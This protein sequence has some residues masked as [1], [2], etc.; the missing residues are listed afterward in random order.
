MND[1]R[2]E[3]LDVI[4]SVRRR[5]RQ[6]LALRG[7][8]AV[9]AGTLVALFLSASSLE[10]LRF[11]P[12]AIVAFRVIA[13]VVFAALVWYFLA[14]PVRRRVS[15]SQV[16]MYLEE[17]DP[18]LEAA[19]LSAVEASSG[20][21]F[22]AS[23]SPHL[24]DR[25]VERAIEQCR[26]AE[27]GHAVD[28][29]ALRRHAMTL[30]GV[31]AAA[32]LLIVV[33]PAYLRSGLSALL[34][35]YRSAAAASPYNIEVQPGDA[36][37]PRGSDQSVRARLLGFE[38]GEATLNVRSSAGASFERIPLVAG[39]DPAV[40]E[41]MLFHVETTT[42][43]FVESNGVHSPTFSL[44]VLDLPTVDRLE[45]EYHF[46]AYTGLPPQRVEFGGDVA[47]LRGTEVRMR[48]VP[49]MK[50]PGGKVLV[51]ESGSGPLTPAPD[52]SLSGGFT[53]DQQGFYRIELTG[54][55]GERVEASP[56]YTIDVLEDQPPIVA[57]T[58]P[59]RDSSASPVE[60]VFLE[61]RADDDFGIRQLQL[62]YTVNGSQEQTVT[63]F[64]GGRTLQ[65]V[66]AG[67]TLFLEELGLEPGDFVS[68]YARAIDNSAAGGSR[69]TTSDIYF[70]QIR[71]FRRDFRAAQSAAG[72]GAGSGSEVGQLSQQQREIVAATFNV[73]RDR[74]K[75]PAD[76]F[77]E[78]VV[79]LTLAQ[80]K[81]RE[82]VDELVGKLQAR[83]GVV[84]SEF[85]KIAELLPKASAEMRSAEGQLKAQQAKDA[86]VP[87]QG[88]LKY[89]QEAEQLYE[90]QVAASQGGGGGSG[91]SALADD[92]ADLFE[93]E[94][95]KLANQ[96]EMEKRAEQQ[97]GDR[98]VDELAA[99]LKELARRQMQ[100]AERQ[101]R[102]AAAGQNQSGGGSGAS[103]RQLAEELEE[104]ARRL[105][106]LTREQQRPEFAEA[107]RRMQE[108]AQ[109]M[110]QAAASG[111]QDG[112]ALANAALDKLREAQRLLERNQSGR[113]ERDIRNAQRQ[114]EE[115]AE[116]QRDITSQVNSLD[117]DGGDR[118]ARAQGLGQRK[119]AMDA[120]VA[121]LQKQLERLANDTR[122]DQR[123]ASRRLDEAANSIRDKRV[124]EKIRYSRNA[125]QG[126]PSDYARAMEED[127][128][129]NLNALEQ[130][131]GDAA[132]ALGEAQKQDALA[133]AVDKTGDLVRSLRS[134]DERMRQDRSESG[135]A[136][137]GQP[138]R[139]GQQGQQGQEGQQGQ[140]QEG[141]GQEGQNGQ[142]EG[143][144]AQGGR[145]G[146]PNGPYNGSP[147]LGGSGDARSWGYGPWNHDDIRQFRREFREWAADAERLRR[148]LA[149][150][151][152]NPRELD[153]IL[154]GLRGLDDERLYADPRGLEKLQAAALERLQKFEFELRKQVDPDRGTLALSASD[155]VPAGFREAIEEYY[156]QLAKKSR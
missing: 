112:G 64:G 70:V 24:V 28:R 113:T 17:R 75:M 91:Q 147:Q 32:A 5:W 52:G 145:F 50:T 152:V 1:R 83:L 115:L 74:A 106:Q 20:S 8:V 110:R 137:G 140:G 126:P 104:A 4:G 129:A 105:Q 117:Q 60:E 151:G 69:T 38:A 148:E 130:K 25:L 123:E 3:L 9:V 81:L 46:P 132:A 61:A 21:E 42:E 19:I 146:N 136:S 27:D 150:A 120:K 58:K 141:R 71:P 47:A 45:L 35:V 55:N 68:Y 62:V 118:Q 10:A 44:S 89:L 124:R 23:H 63:L 155:E 84:D 7:V 66:T 111:A 87:E 33:G 34:V 6:R 2:A 14:R 154:R 29:Q 57:F 94:L 79:F 22:A 78:D 131:I 15:D 128:G 82:Q 51:N 107:A 12:A 86:L 11:S 48:V 93:L 96:Y 56:K 109:A 90:M 77:R 122:R 36:K 98:S 144:T 114:A 18:S 95:D 153:E 127:I 125:L 41:G 142:G 67:H 149:A 103:Q 80:A 121:D 73:V 85:R 59:G 54:P 133:R 65:E 16:A 143:R 135:Q 26:T 156:R 88:A 72:M 92:L 37:V 139:R 13:A 49:S 43:Y 97:A 31:L 76:K 40:F 53:I 39:S 134:L 99:K 100:E 116:E 108:A 101:R 138:G 119:D 102:L 30:G